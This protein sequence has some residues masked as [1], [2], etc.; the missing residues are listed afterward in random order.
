VGRHAGAGR[1]PPAVIARLSEAMRQS[2][3]KPETR[4]RIAKLG[5]ITVGDTPAQFRAFL[6]QDIARWQRVIT[7]SG[8]KPDERDRP[9][10]AVATL[11]LPPRMRKTGTMT[12]LTQHRV[13][14]LAA[15]VLLL[16]GWRSSPMAEAD[17]LQQAINYV[18]TGRV[19]PASEPA[20]VDRDACIVLVPEPVN[21][22]SVRYYLGRFRMDLAQVEK[23]YAGRLPTY[24]LSVEGDDDVVE[25]LNPDKTVAHGHRT[26]QIPLPGEIELTQRA[27]RLIAERCKGQRPKPPF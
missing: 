11:A 5:G 13:R 17:A 6:K 10:C 25:F 14:V 18:F 26:A 20:I 1:D 4:E 15:A 23:I 8:I 21:R 7:A 9:A 24:R 27:L 16:I 2:L 3:A 19:D 12:G 22:R